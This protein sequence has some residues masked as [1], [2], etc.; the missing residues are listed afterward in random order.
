[1]ID[2]KENKCVYKIHHNL[3]YVWKFRYVNLDM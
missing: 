1:M 3:R 2:N